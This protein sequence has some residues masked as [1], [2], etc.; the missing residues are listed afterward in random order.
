MT[1]RF[2]PSLPENGRRLDAETTTSRSLHLV[3]TTLLVLLSLSYLISAL[4]AFNHNDFMYAV[5]PTFLN[6]YTLYKD[7]EF[8]QAPGSI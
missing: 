8:V 2:V 4:P 7:L 3:I 1:S 6:D 5:A